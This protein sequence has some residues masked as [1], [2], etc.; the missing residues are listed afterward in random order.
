M[1]QGYGHYI[2]NTGE[3]DLEV[4]IVLNSGVYQSISITAWM[5]ANTPELLA[6][7]FQVPAAA[8]PVS[9]RTRSSC[10]KKANKDRRHRRMAGTR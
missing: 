6:T 5:A 10:P 3:D 9:P 7:N 1:P 8:S 4:L 2:E